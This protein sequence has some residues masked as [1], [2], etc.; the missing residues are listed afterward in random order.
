MAEIGIQFCG[1]FLIVQLVYFSFRGKNLNLSSRRIY[2]FTLFSALVCLTSDILSIYALDYFYRVPLPFTWIVCKLYVTGLVWVSFGGFSYVL[3]GIENWAHTKAAFFVSRVWL[4]IGT[5]LIWILPIYFHTENDDFYTYGASIMATYLFAVSFVL[6]TI[7]FSIRFR[8]HMASRRFGSMLAWMLIWLAAA[9][10]Q[11]M[12]STLPLV[13]FATALGLNIIYAELE[14]PEANIDNETGAFTAHALLL[15]MEQFFQRGRTFSGLTVILIP[16]DKNLNREESKVLMVS[17]ARLLMGVSGATVF[18]NIGNEFMVLFE[19]EDAM[20]SG[21]EE[22]RSL[23]SKPIPADR[24][25]LYFETRY[26][27]MPSSEVA[28]GA[29]DIFWFRSYFTP[30]GIESDF[31]VIDEDTVKSFHETA[32]IKE[33]IGEALRDERIEVFYQPIYSTKRHRFVSAE[34]LARIR[35][36]DGEI[37]PPGVFIPV[38]EQS[39]LILQIGEVVFRQVCDFLSRIDIRALGMHYV[40]VNLSV[41]QIEQRTLAA[42][43]RRIV[44]EAGID[45][46]LL[47]LEITES[48]TVSSRNTLIQNMTTLIEQGMRFSLDDFGTGQSNLDYVLT[49]PV[50]FIKFDHTLTRAYF[51]DE[52]ARFVVESTIEMV[53]K[54]G[55]EIVAEGI[56]TKE[57]L[58]RMVE[59]GVSFIQGFYFS[60]PIPEQEFLSFVR[61]RNYRA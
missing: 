18:R 43:Y 54:L 3:T 12:V 44:R 10:V 5:A 25:M 23:L 56:E 57:Q 34:A 60:K 26:I 39:D 2:A 1:L 32:A 46:T 45:P 36:K 21:Y 8:K 33:M 50:D 22:I 61:E 59:L 38:A 16:D 28:S 52:K 13:G 55:L 47:N 19:N 6:A 20:S 15:Y 30:S 17:A 51:E 40:E 4:L 41:A 14:N 42:D 53:K 7:F 49:M 35:G 31:T 58:D 24:R 29:D 27:L 9:V 48:A 11:F 37:I